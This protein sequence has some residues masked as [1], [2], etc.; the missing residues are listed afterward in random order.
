MLI[1]CPDCGTEG[2]EVGK[3]CENCGRSLTEADAGATQ[4]DPVTAPTMP[5]PAA[6]SDPQPPGG[7]QFA[8]VTE[9]GV[10]PANGFTIRQ[11]GEFLV[12]RPDNEAGTKPDIDLRQ[13]VKP[14]DVGGQQQYLVSRRQCYLGITEEGTVT[15]RA[16]EGTVLTTLVRPVGQEAFV[17]M[18]QLGTVRAAL[19][20]PV[21]AYPLEKGDR[22]FMGDP[23]ALPHFLS[24][25]ATGRGSYLVLELV[26]DAT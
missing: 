23:D 13:W 26:S 17:P 6:T 20:E 12:G 25:D 16:L 4:S 1:R 2:Q 21:G 10:D 14:L 22:I 7:A 24:G 3:Y 8:V 18:Q 19:T 5:V 15:I 11:K 9:K